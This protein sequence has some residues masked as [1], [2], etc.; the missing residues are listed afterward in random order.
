[1][2]E[3]T[4]SIILLLVGVSLFIVGMNLM[5]SGLKKSTGP[6]L[7]R[8]FNKIQ[9]NRFAGLGIGAGVT[10]LIQS[11]GATSVMTIGFINTGVMTMFQGLAIIL[12]AYIGTTITG[13]LVSFSSFS[14]SYFL[15][16]FAFVGVVM[17]FFKNEKI[18]NLG[19]VFT[20]F[21]VLFFGLETMKG[22]FTGELLTW[23]QNVFASIDF[24]L[25]LLLIGALF[26]ALTQSSSATT[27]IVIVMCGSGALTLT[28]GLYIALGATIGTVLVTIMASLSGTID[29]KRT[30]LSCL[31]I[32]TIT[33]ILAL[34]IVWPVEACCGQAISNGLYTLFGGTPG[35]IPLNATATQFA[36][37][38]FM[39]FYNLIFVTAVLPFMQWFIDLSTK[40]LP[41]KEALKKRRA[42]KY[43]DNNMLIS[44]SVA[45]HQAKN[46]IVNM[47]DL[48]EANIKLGYEMAV[49]TT[50]DHMDELNEREEDIDNINNELT[51]FLISL[52]H[53][54]ASMKQEKKI[55]GYFHIVNDIERIGDHACNFADI[56]KKMKEADLHFSDT[57][58][59]E[60][61]EMYDCLIQMFACARE[62]FITHKIEKLK[63]LHQLEDK[64]DKLKITL[65]EGHFTRITNNTCVMELSP[66]YSSLISDL[67][68]VADHL[69][70]VGYAYIN[71]TGDDENIE[72]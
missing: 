7:K 66:F 72:L 50:L 52:S 28:S 39:V 58:K 63:E 62:V 12:G 19:E 53:A 69:V 41:D 70:N 27:G 11:S 2:N 23:C 25:L 61:Q 51:N 24:P 8:L 38:F 56:A 9:N 57:A 55:G 54:D 33:A 30:A 34:A 60:L 14:F 48:S 13:V 67:E 26:T 17:S 29:A 71:P 49:N 42:I 16:L 65:S 37:A 46:E 3:I 4:K 40:L 35:E 32:R 68:R 6:S 36:V 18:K 22:A 5:S 45:I 1:M 15:V 21:G 47:L 43:I 31:I 59:T 64:T 20:G 44:P 10:A